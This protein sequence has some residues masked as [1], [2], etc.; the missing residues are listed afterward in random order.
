MAFTKVQQQQKCESEMPYTYYLSILY[1]L[2]FT[3]ITFPLCSYEHL[4]IDLPL[5]H[6]H[7]GCV[8]DADI[9]H[10]PL[11]LVQKQTW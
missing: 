9:C 6:V 7:E 11:S 8:R 5:H 3:D 10:D 1:S 2:T 4:R